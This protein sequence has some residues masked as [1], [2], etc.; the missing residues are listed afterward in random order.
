M[1]ESSASQKSYSENNLSPQGRHYGLDSTDRRD[2]V[3]HQ[4]NTTAAMNK[5]HYQES[6]LSSVPG[7]TGRKSQPSVRVDNRPCY[8]LCPVNDLYQITLQ[9]EHDGAPSSQQTMYDEGPQR[10]STVHQSLDIVGEATEQ[11]RQSQAE[12]KQ[13]DKNRPLK[14]R[15]GKARG[16]HDTVDQSLFRALEVKGSR[17]NSAHEEGSLERPSYRGPDLEQYSKAK[18]ARYEMQ[19]A[20]NDSTVSMNQGRFD[21]FIPQDWGS[22]PAMPYNDQ[23]IYAR[24]TTLNEPGINFE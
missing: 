12:K 14:S 18:I 24:S 17:E 22:S 10:Y 11:L 20:S 4:I 7:K 6:N 1:P 8:K 13:N 15:L 23:D 5:S 21:A 9:V 2:E 3:L 16:H 19:H